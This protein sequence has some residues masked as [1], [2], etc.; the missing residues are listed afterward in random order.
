M[1][2]ISFESPSES[3]SK[4]IGFKGFKKGEKRSDVP[5][6]SLRNS[7]RHWIWWASRRPR[8]PNCQHRLHE[9]GG[10]WQS[11]EMPTQDLASFFSLSC[12]IFCDFIFFVSFSDVLIKFRLPYVETTVGRI[13]Q[14]PRYTIL[15]ILIPN[16]AS[17][18]PRPRGILTRLQIRQD[19]LVSWLQK[20][21]WT[22]RKQARMRFLQKAS[23]QLLVTIFPLNRVSF[24]D[25]P[26]WNKVKI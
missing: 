8:K 6:F 15:F 1:W 13:P 9:T 21:T 14:K 17:H 16:T 5:N 24:L 12:F 2:S 10:F 26:A 11:E 18:L 3:S 22:Q 19:S 4:A 7:S 23:D 25:V 20:G